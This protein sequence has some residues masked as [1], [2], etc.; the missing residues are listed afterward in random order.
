[1]ALKRKINQAAYDALADALKFEYKKAKED[2][3]LLEVDDATDLINARDN[4]KREKEAFKVENDNL[5]KELKTIKDSGSNWETMEASY[6]E[7]LVK[8]DTEIGTLNTTLTTE[9]RDRHT[10]AAAAK[11]AGRFTVPSV[12]TPL[13]AKRLDIDPRD[14]TKVVVL[15][16]T[17][18]V[19]ALTLDDL[20]KEF[21]DNA[22]FKP[23]VI[24]HK[25]SGSAANGLP[26]VPGKTTDNNTPNLISKMTPVQIAEA[27]K[28][29]KAE[30][31]NGGAA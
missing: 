12:M 26:V 4:E 8:K 9:R 25:G 21:V 3:F 31:A 5:K 10:S 30:A 7:Q 17:G 14:P 23:M 24:A 1:M 16:A 27:R 29:A 22:E 13:I 19:S 6:K 18:K 15:D 20:T 28:A 2:E 11:I